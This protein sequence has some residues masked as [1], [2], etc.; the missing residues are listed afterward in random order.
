[1]KTSRCKKE[2]IDGTICGKPAGTCVHNFAPTR[3]G[4]AKIEAE[5]RSEPS[6]TT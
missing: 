4:P 1:M 3:F 5:R 2:N 6:R